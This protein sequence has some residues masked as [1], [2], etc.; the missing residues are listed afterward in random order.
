M[1]KSPIQSF[2][3][4]RTFCAQRWCD[5][6]KWRTTVPA[7]PELLRALRR[8]LSFN[9]IL[10]LNPEQYEERAVAEVLPDS[11]RGFIGGR[12]HTYN[13]SSGFEVTDAVKFELA[14]R[15]E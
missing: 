14:S 8:N 4:R 1:D 5:C 6:H 3:Y 13:S 11:T 7:E 12:G 9:E 15:Y 2:L 10:I